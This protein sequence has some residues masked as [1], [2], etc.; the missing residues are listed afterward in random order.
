MDSTFVPT[1]PTLLDVSLE[2]L[3]AAGRSLTPVARVCVVGKLAEGTTGAAFGS[4]SESTLKKLCPTAFSTDCTRRSN[5]R[6]AA[7]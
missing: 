1:K 3:E 5:S 6:H 4:W 7:R 2:R